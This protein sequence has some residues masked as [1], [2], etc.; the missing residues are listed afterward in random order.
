VFAT[1]QRWNNRAVEI[2]R[3][4]ADVKS[5]KNAMRLK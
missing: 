4:L 1:L 2:A 5:V 3:G